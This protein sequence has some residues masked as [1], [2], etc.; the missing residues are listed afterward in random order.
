MPSYRRLGLDARSSVSEIRG[1]TK[2]AG[3][4]AALVVRKASAQ[5]LGKTN[6]L[7]VK[8][9]SSNLQDKVAS[10]ERKLEGLGWLFG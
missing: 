9:A 1:I 3:R 2:A 8:G 6:P 4:K 10:I 7:M 5:E